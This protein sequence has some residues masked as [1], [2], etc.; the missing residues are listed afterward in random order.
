MLWHHPCKSL[1]TSINSKWVSIWV[2][3]VFQFGSL[4]GFEGMGAHLGVQGS[5]IM[6][7]KS[8]ATSPRSRHPYP[9]SRLRPKSTASAGKTIPLTNKRLGTSSMTHPQSWGA[10]SVSDKRQSI[11]PPFVYNESCWKSGS[12]FFSPLPCQGWARIRGRYTTIQVQASLKR[13]VTQWGPLPVETGRTTSSWSEGLAFS[14]LKARS[15]RLAG[16]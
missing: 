15:Y 14:H 13:P 5:L 16:W 1:D 8:T 6:L 12:S 7:K 4:F 11:R 3:P 2:W 9:R 10:Y